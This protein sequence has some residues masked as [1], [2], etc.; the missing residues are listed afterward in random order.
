M[1]KCY[2]NKELFFKL[3]NE[4]LKVLIARGKSNCVVT[5]VN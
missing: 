1:M 4:L 2:F 3:L 5:D